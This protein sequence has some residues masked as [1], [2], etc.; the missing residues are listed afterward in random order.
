MK[1]IA[2]IFSLF[3]LIASCSD[4]DENVNRMELVPEPDKD[5][6]EESEKQQALKMTGCVF[7]EPDSSV[8][9]IQLRDAESTLRVLGKQSWLPGDSTHLFY[10]GDKK[11][12]LGLTV[13]AGDYA[14][15]VSV[16]RVSYAPASKQNYPRID[17]KVFETEKGIRL[18]IS[19]SE[20]TGKLGRCCTVKDST[21]TTITLN[22]RKE[23]DLWYYATY[24]F[25]NNKLQTMVFGY[26]YP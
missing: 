23:Q 9:G 3:L 25:R 15:Q 7:S 18:G 11:Q 26:E 13:F 6:R 1:N 2:C 12:V 21:A 4:N 22:Y 24:Q 14:N 16:F 8:A 17:S 10:S 5:L 19:K 20:L